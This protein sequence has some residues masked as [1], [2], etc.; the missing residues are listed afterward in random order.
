MN[1]KETGDIVAMLTS[2]AKTATDQGEG[3]TARVLIAQADM[4]AQGMHVR[5]LEEVPDMMGDVT[6]F[7][8][9]F[10]LEYLGKPRMLPHGLFQFRHKFAIEE[11]MEHAEEQPKLDSAIARADHREIVNSLETQLDSL[12]DEVYVA[13]GTA[14]LQFGGKVFNEAWRRVHVANM[15]KVRA[16]AD[17]DA[18][19]H[20]DTK[21][22]VVKPE[23]WVAPDHRDLVTDHAHVLYRKGAEDL[24]PDYAAGNKTRASA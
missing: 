1:D 8:Q 19:S 21:Y 12:V 16:E 6:Q 24:N 9:H 13:L 14:Y 4:I 3:H 2:A 15:L 11:V 7:H 18:R 20:R 23:G 10:G 22:D 17:E 5:N